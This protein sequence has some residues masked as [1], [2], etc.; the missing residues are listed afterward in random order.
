MKV[1]YPKDYCNMT[2][3][4]CS[5]VPLQPLLSALVCSHLPWQQCRKT[6]VLHRR[7]GKAQTDT[8]STFICAAHESLVL[9]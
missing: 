8:A 3:E 9:I 5:R 1:H 2:L 6:S 7:F 4:H